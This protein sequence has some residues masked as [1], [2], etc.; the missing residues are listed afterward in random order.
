MERG[1]G[2]RLGGRRWCSIK[3]KQGATRWILV[4]LKGLVHWLKTVMLGMPVMDQQVDPLKEV[5]LVVDRH[6]GWLALKG[7]QTGLLRTEELV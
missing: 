3:G 2:S 4:E 5:K 7:W 1:V 6:G